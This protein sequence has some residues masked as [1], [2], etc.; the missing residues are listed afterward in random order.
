MDIQC[1]AFRWD[2]TF[3]WWCKGLFVVNSVFELMCFF[4]CAFSLLWM[5]LWTPRG[6]SRRKCE[7]TFCLRVC[8]LFCIV[9]LGALRPLMSIANI[10]FHHDLREL[11]AQPT[12]FRLAVC[13]LVLQYTFVSACI[14]SFTS[15][16]NLLVHVVKHGH[17]GTISKTVVPMMIARILVLFGMTTCLLSSVQPRLF[18]QMLHIWEWAVWLPSLLALWILVRIT[19]LP[20]ILR[21]RESSQLQAPQA[22]H[23]TPVKAE[24]CYCPWVYR[25]VLRA[26]SLIWDS[27]DTGSDSDREHERYNAPDLEIDAETHLYAEILAVRVA[28]MSSVLLIQIFVSVFVLVLETSSFVQ[29]ATQFF[30]SVMT[31]LEFCTSV[32]LLLGAVCLHSMRLRTHFVA[33]VFVMPRH[34]G[35][36]PS[37]TRLRT[38]SQPLV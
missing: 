38:L 7:S 17:K 25:Q 35:T 28:L 21:E 4:M 37:G 1:F 16:W 8:L 23:A 30:Q 10:D 12:T 26:S 32:G 5:R 36:N 9:R 33:T 3:P 14:C 6:H 27:A 22:Q 19:C 13:A 11:A 31:A 20:K 18:T 15:Y 24:L 29:P 2:N 34:A